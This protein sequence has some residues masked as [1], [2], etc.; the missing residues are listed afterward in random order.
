MPVEYATKMHMGLKLNALTVPLM[1]TTYLLVQ[2]K[3]PLKSMSSKHNLSYSMVH[4]MSYAESTEDKESRCKKQRLSLSLSCSVFRSFHIVH[5]KIPN[6]PMM[7]RHSSLDSIYERKNL[8]I[9]EI[10]SHRLGRAPIK[11]PPPP[12]AAVRLNKEWRKNC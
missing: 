12:L 3:T 5:C 11:Q 1:V 10:F 2:C 9:D 6:Y 8:V 7:T 4:C